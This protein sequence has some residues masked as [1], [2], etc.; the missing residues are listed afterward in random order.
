MAEV[1]TRL[2]IGEGLEAFQARD[3]ALDEGASR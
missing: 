2:L 3:G 1:D